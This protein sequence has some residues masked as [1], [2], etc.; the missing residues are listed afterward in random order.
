MIEYPSIINSSK[1]PRKACFAFAKYDGSNIRVKYTQ[2]CGFNLFGSRNCL[3][4]ETHEHLGEVVPLFME[5]FAKPL[6]DV[7]K[8][9]YPNER[10][11]VVFGEFLGQKSYAGI[12]EKSDPKEF[13][14]FDVMLCGKQHNKFVNPKDFVKTF[15][16]IVR[17]A[18]LVYDGNL[19]EEL[20][21]DVRA[22]KYNVTEGVICKGTEK[23]GAAR[24]GIWMAK[25]K[26]QKYLDSLKER[27][28]QDWEKYGE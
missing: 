20:I 10:E 6:T 9:L 17:T 3:I 2:K 16:P 15:A 8:K 4:D 25:I 12:H 22:G 7:F 11:I 5:G 26:T 27:F 14:M 24:G 18:E 28:G 21:A 19:N 23:T 13:I 1:A